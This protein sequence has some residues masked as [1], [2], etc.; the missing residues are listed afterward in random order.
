[1]RSEC[2]QIQHKALQ[3]PCSVHTKPQPSHCHLTQ[4]AISL[5][6]RQQ[7]PSS[8]NGHHS[9]QGVRRSSSMWLSP[10]P[11][12]VEVPRLSCVGQVGGGCAPLG[13]TKIN[14]HH[15]HYVTPNSYHSSSCF[16]CSNRHNPKL[17]VSHEAYPKDRRVL[18]PLGSS[19]CHQPLSEIT[20]VGS[21]HEPL[22]PEISLAG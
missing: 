14:S 15:N 20:D 16:G 3:C 11:P 22:A 2:I 4:T 8:S 19:V 7:P 6:Q 1:M 12:A 10:W 21:P 17:H 13:N 5:K 18:L 9:H